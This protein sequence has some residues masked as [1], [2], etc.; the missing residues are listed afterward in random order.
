MRIVT[1]FN[2]DAGQ[3]T[4][5]NVVNEVADWEPAATNLLSYPRRFDNG[6]WGKNG[7]AKFFP[8]TFLAPDG[9]LTAVKIAGTASGG[10]VFKLNVAASGMVKSIYLRTVSGTGKIGSLVNSNTQVFDINE[11]WQRFDYPAGDSGA[12]EHFYVADFRGPSTLT[13]VVVWHAQLE[14]GTVPTGV[15]PDATTFTSRASTATLIDSTGTLQAAGVDVARDDAY[16]YVDGVLKPI[17]LLLEGAGTNLISNTNSSEGWNTFGLSILVGGA[18][19]ESSQFINGIERVV[20]RLPAGARLAFTYPNSLNGTYTASAR[21]RVISGYEFGYFSISMAGAVD[22]SKAIT[23]SETVFSTI[24]RTDF[25]SGTGTGEV[26]IIRRTDGG[27][28]DVLVEVE[29]QQLEESSFITSYIPTQGSQV[30]RAADVSSSPQ[31]TRAA[32]EVFKIGGPEYSDQEGT[33][34]L[35]YSS[36]SLSSDA[37]RLVSIDG[38]VSS[39]KEYLQVLINQYSELEFNVASVFRG[40]DYGNHQINIGGRGSNPI[41]VVAYSQQK[42][43]LSS[44]NDVGDVVTAEVDVVPGFLNGSNYIRFLRQRIYGGNYNTGTLESVRY[45]P[46]KLTEFEIATLIKGT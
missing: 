10:A 7:D 31:V 36:V 35:K 46:T 18:T 1:P 32:D 8:E 11:N 43:R 13:E 21:V 14:E 38:N 33:F 45:F 41:V 27:E 42:I 22:F 26:N 29:Q 9:T 24:S 37:A 17:G 3:L 6:Y 40:Q 16:G 34:L 25:I 28:E 23:L 2:V 44:I 12:D 19:I 39:E 20:I 15:I 4:T 5:T 30:T